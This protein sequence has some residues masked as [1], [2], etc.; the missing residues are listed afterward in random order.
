MKRFITLYFLFLGILFL[1]FI[2]PLFDFSLALNYFQTEFT[3][4]VLDYFLDENQRIGSDIW[5]D[6]GYKIVITN[7]CNG[8]MPLFFL[9]ASIFAYPSSLWGKVFWM[10]LGYVILF[11]VNIIRIVWVVFVT[12]EGKGQEE[13]YW[14]HDIVGNIF[15]MFWGLVLFVGFIKISGKKLE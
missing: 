5:I 12:Q 2:S 7:A 9:Y 15:L 3:L 6:S 11:V 1:V 13:F 8:L 10:F 14:S 4:V